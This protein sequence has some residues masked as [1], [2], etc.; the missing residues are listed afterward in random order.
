VFDRGSALEYASLNFDQVPFKVARSAR[1]L[2]NIALAVVLV[3]GG[4]IVNT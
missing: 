2:S 4:F 1:L 3:Y